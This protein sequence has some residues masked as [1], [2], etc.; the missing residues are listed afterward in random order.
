MAGKFDLYS[1]D[2]LHFSLDEINLLVSGGTPVKLKKGQ[3]LYYVGESGDM[4]YFLR[5][6]TAK[7]HVVL[8][9]GSSR[10]T[11]FIEAPDLLGVINVL[12]DHSTLNCCSAVTSCELIACPSALF[13]E[14]V[15]RY[16]L[17]DKLFRFSTETARHI[18][19]TLTQ[20][21]S[22]D[23]VELIKH[24]RND[25]GLTLQETADFI[26]YSRVHVS[27]IMKKLEEEAADAPC[28]PDTES[29]DS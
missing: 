18:F 11:A 21:L 2:R 28:K 22:D 12:P 29:S 17:M 27:R 8:P 25:L 26:G 7:Y 6:G 3:L 15:Q 14:R 13:L 16:N 1:A 20:L 19:T 23:R 10:N 9:D 24:L 4:V 5:K